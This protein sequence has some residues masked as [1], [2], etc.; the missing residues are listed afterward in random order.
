[1]ARFAQHVRVPAAPGRRDELAAKFLETIEFLRDNPDCEL[2][3][4]S[5]DPDDP[6]VVVLTEVWTSAE[7]HRATVAGEHVQRWAEGMPQLTAGPPTVQRL[8]VAGL[9]SR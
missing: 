9:L 4:V 3:L 6:D 7:A 8:E 1:M 2:T 5:T